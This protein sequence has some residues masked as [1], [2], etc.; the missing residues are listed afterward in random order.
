MAALGCAGLDAPPDEGLTPA[1]ERSVARAPRPV[2]EGQSSPPA[3]PAEPEPA[4]PEAPG[5]CLVHFAPGQTLS[6]R[7]FMDV[8]RAEAGMVVASS[9]GAVRLWEQ[10][11]VRVVARTGA[12]MV[13]IAVGAG[14]REVAVVGHGVVARSSDGG[15]NFRTHPFPGGRLLYAAAFSGEDLL[16]F[17]AEGGGWRGRGGASWQPLLLPRTVAWFG[18][19]FADERRGYLAGNCSTLIETRDGGATWEELQAPTDAEGVAAAGDVVLVAGEDGL[20]R[21]DDRGRSFEKVED[22]PCIRVKLDG[23]RAAA[24]CL[25]GGGIVGHS[26]FYSEDGGSTYTRLPLLVT[27]PVPTLF[28]V[29]FT[30]LVDRGP[31]LLAVGAYEHLFEVYSRVGR[32]RYRTDATDCW[33]GFMGVYGCGWPRQRPKPENA[34]EFW[35]KCSHVF[36]DGPQCAGCAGAKQDEGD[37]QR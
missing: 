8:A 21:S 2:K 30:G 12:A 19:A 35:K 5:D 33:E 9:D 13:G 22:G 18:V 3:P 4:D 11:E 37:A 10:G 31:M 7:I 17:D 27:Y 14:G 1:S 16:V 26:P 32:I 20:F 15:L 6:Q 36:P 25:V 23:R 29:A 28:G 34:A 24:S